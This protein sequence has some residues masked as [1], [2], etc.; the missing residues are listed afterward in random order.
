MVESLMLRR[1]LLFTKKHVIIRIHN[2][3]GKSFSTAWEN[4]SL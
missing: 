1:E 4:P 3:M 2:G